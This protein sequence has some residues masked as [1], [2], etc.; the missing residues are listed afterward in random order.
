MNHVEVFQVEEI[1]YIELRVN[2]D[3]KRRGLTP[4]SISVAYSQRDHLWC[5]C[6]VVKEDAD[7]V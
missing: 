7:N 5:V 3:C 4:I 1:D 2:N 6:V